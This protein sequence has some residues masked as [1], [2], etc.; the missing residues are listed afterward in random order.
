M[1]SFFQ[2][3]KNPIAQVHNYVSK[4]LDDLDCLKST[5]IMKG[6]RS[7][8]VYSVALVC[9]AQQAFIKCNKGHSGYYSCEICTVKAESGKERIV[10]NTQQSY[11]KRTDAQCDAKD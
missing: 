8:P 3:K 10:F 4:F 6:E 9:D 7:V 5:G 2:V 1:F 11:E